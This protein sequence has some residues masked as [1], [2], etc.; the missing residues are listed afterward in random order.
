MIKL[1]QLWLTLSYVLVGFGDEKGTPKAR[2]SKKIMGTEVQIVVDSPMSD[3]L[4][5][6]TD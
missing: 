5:K 6:A 2:F 4:K 1:L 3:A